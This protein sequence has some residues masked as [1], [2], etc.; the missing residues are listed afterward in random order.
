[1]MVSLA[2][3]IDTVLEQM[4]R[5]FPEIRAA[6][7]VS[8]EGFPISSVTATGIQ[9]DPYVAASLFGGVAS[10]AASALEETQQGDLQ[11]LTMEGRDGITM[12]TILP[13]KQVLTVIASS[14]VRLGLLFG[15]VRKYA[16]KLAE[17]LEGS[18]L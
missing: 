16:R 4:R 7:L 15:Q 10:I 11:Q 8:E 12:V 6:F 3:Q 2:E 14:D 1:M 13:E 5:Q 18:A 17:V 9:I